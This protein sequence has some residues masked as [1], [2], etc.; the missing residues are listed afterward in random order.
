[1]IS[2]HPFVNI[3]FIIVGQIPTLAIY[4]LFL[5]QSYKYPDY[6]FQGNVLLKCSYLFYEFMSHVEFAWI[7]LFAAICFP[8]FLNKSLDSDPDPNCL[9]Y[10]LGFLIKYKM[11]AEPG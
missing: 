7:N 1:M 4:N 5:K 11:P 3:R 9:C 10:R 6:G 2:N 8:T